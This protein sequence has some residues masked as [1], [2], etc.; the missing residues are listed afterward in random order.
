M[1]A[2]FVSAVIVT[3]AAAGRPATAEA[4]QDPDAPRILLDQ[5]ARM[6]EYQLSRLSDAELTSLERKA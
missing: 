6:V 4:R 5:P 3:L 2:A 1:A